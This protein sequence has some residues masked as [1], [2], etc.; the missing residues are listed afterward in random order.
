MASDKQTIEAAAQAW[1]ECGGDR[2]GLFFCLNQLA[3]RIQEICD[4]RDSSE[5]SSANIGIKGSDTTAK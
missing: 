1:V 3:E 4:E 2:D 5:I